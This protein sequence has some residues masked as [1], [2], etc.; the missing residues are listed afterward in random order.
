MSHAGLCRRREKWIFQQA[1]LFDDWKDLQ[2]AYWFKLIA[3]RRDYEA[4]SRKKCYS[5]R[6]GF[7]LRGD[8]QV[9]SNTSLFLAFQS[10]LPDR[11]ISSRWR[12]KAN[13]NTKR[14]AS[15]CPNG[16]RQWSQPEIETRNA[17][18]LSIRDGM[19]IVWQWFDF[20]RVK[21]Q[22]K[23][24]TPF[25]FICHQRFSSLYGSETSGNLLLLTRFNHLQSK[26]VQR[27][28]NSKSM[29]SAI[30]L[31]HISDSLQ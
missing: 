1:A 2:S 4:S 31:K 8:C 11:K 25:E 26:A 3:G 23:T 12:I 7:G 10:E 5:K 22:Q 18:L 21:E 16:N 17:K 19:T 30:L 14:V 15:T 24:K 29:L 20:S 13:V 6:R 28:R 27:G 9:P